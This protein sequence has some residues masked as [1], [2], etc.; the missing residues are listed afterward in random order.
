MASADREIDKTS[1]AITLINLRDWLGLR[2]TVWFVRPFQ[3]DS[4][5]RRGVAGREVS[6]P[7]F[8]RFLNKLGGASGNRRN[9]HQLVARG[10]LD[11]P[12]GELFVTLEM[13]LAMRTGEFEIAHNDSGY[14]EGEFCQE[15]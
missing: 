9:P 4:L 15:K 12:A 3:R 14:R 1:F 10:A 7:G 6:R 2:S 13:L 5:W 8:S 11:L